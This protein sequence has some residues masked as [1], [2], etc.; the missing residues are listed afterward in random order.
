MIPQELRQVSAEV[1]KKFSDL[2][3]KQR[4]VSASSQEPLPASE[5]EIKSFVTER[6]AV[7]K[8]AVENY[9]EAKKVLEHHHKQGT[10]DE[11]KIKRMRKDL[12]DNKN[13]FALERGALARVYGE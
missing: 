8:D 13:L 4:A 1:D 12:D 3:E 7:T 5:Y 10:F 6:E 2:E 9:M 11:T